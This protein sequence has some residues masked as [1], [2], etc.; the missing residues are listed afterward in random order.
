MMNFL[1]FPRGEPLIKFASVETKLY[2]EQT[3]IK[4]HVSPIGSRSNIVRLLEGLRI[5]S[6]YLRTDPGRNLQKRL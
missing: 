3:V 1:G 5:Y 4:L 2:V 6:H